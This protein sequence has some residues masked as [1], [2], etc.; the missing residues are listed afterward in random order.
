MYYYKVRQQE[1][2]L[3][4]T[5]RLPSGKKEEEE[6]E[7]IYTSFEFLHILYYCTKPLYN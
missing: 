5:H 2:F 4:L 6:E 1:V 3:C 7:Q